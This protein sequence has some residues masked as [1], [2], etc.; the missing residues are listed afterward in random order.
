MGELN[1][2]APIYIAAAVA[3]GLLVCMALLM[4]CARYAD[5]TGQAGDAD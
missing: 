1:A 5:A 2:G 3:A 4:I